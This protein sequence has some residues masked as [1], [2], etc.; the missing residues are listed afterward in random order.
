MSVFGAERKGI[1][2]ELALTRL[3][4]PDAKNQVT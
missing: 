2:K 4:A 3:S 1:T